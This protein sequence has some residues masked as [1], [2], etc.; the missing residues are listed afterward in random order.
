MGTRVIRIEELDTPGPHRGRGLL[1]S[2]RTALM[3]A[4]SGSVLAASLLFASLSSGAGPGRSL[5]AG[6]HPEPAPPPTRPTP[7]AP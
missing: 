4:V 3:V 6:S 2:T 5:T 7:S 1:D